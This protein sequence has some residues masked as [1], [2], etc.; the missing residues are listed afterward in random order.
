MSA[1]TTD[2]CKV[3]QLIYS[4]D[5]I[6]IIFWIEKWGF[7]LRN[8]TSYCLPST[9]S[10]YFT[11]FLPVK[12]NSS[13]W[14]WCYDY[15]YHTNEEAEA[16]AGYKTHPGLGGGRAE[17]KLSNLVPRHLLFTLCNT[18]SRKEVIIHSNS[19]I[20]NQEFLCLASVHFHNC[21]NMIDKVHA[22]TRMKRT[23]FMKLS[24]PH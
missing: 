4:K 20:Q 16:Q 8:K 13:L 18:V 24:Q 9:K 14:G 7:F 22:D 17:M 10:Q 11:Q 5:L 12:L 6:N 19:W 3:Q 23:F 15:T 1:I 2:I 21:K